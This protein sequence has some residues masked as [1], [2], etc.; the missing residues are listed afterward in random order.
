MKFTS[1]R[2]F[3]LSPF[4]YFGWADSTEIQEQKKK[5]T[6]ELFN[7]DRYKEIEKMSMITRNPEKYYYDK[8]MIRKQLQECRDILVTATKNNPSLFFLLNYLEGL[9]LY[10]KL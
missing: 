10:S 5:N 8:E 7:D 6:I 9:I 4:I 3:L 1:F 2:D